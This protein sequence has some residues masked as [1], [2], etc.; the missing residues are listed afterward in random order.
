MFYYE[1]LIYNMDVII[2]IIMVKLSGRVIQQT[3]FPHS[4]TSRPES[5]TLQTAF[6]YII[7]ITFILN[8]EKK[9]R[10]KVCCLFIITFFNCRYLTTFLLPTQCS[11]TNQSKSF[12]SN[13]VITNLRKTDSIFRLHKKNQVSIFLC[14]CSSVMNRSNYYD[15]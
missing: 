10:N 1:L 11:D 9:H 6:N 7:K 15:G 14:S 4:L 5:G 13:L 12:T 3:A 8:R 2:I